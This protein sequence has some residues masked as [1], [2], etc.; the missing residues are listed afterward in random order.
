MLPLEEHAYHYSSKGIAVPLKESEYGKIE[1]ATEILLLAGCWRNAHWSKLC[2]CN[3]TV[4]RDPGMP[5]NPDG[6]MTR[7]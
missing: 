1:I 3:R 5:I 6:L 2:A 7:Q 4:D